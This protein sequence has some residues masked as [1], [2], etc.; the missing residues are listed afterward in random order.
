MSRATASQ[1]F[2]N[3][4]A[5][6]WLFLLQSVVLRA[7][8]TPAS[9]IAPL[10]KHYFNSIISIDGYNKPSVKLDT[11]SS[12]DK[13]LKNYGVKQLSV[14]FCLPLVTKDKRGTG[15]DSNVMA[16]THLLLTGNFISLQPVFSG[17]DNHRLVKRGIGLRYIYNT[18]KK[19]VWFFDVAPFVTRDVSYTSRAY[20]RLASTAVYSHN[21]SD[22]FNFRVGLTKSFMWGN[23]LY[24][25]FLGLRFGALNKTHL[26]IQFPRN[27]SFNVPVNRHVILGLYTRPQGG[28]YNF[29][30][31]DTL[32][33][34]ANVKTFHF[35][36]YELNTGLR[37][38]VRVG[39]HFG[40]FACSGISSRNNITFYSDA[41]NKSNGLPYRKY[42]YSAS[43]ARTGYLQLGLVVKLGKTR[44]ISNN[45]NL[46]DAIDLNSST[47]TNDGN[48]Q[49]QVDGKEKPLKN[50]N[51]ESIQ[52]L[53]DYNDF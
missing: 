11:S 26:S 32:Y 40:F 16:N 39:S 4:Q 28:M 3:L 13:R 46:Y 48:R 44:T 45:R 24:L 30:N 29:A 22:K 2:Y 19:G 41:V 18:G 1:T 35:T 37:V 53:I 49:I 52:D 20:R 17:I 42:F 50:P 33:F 14:A 25:P 34:N 9:T 15:A 12:L 51:L 43:P 5:W 10:P 7:Q 21:V 27:I 6:L 36:R 47:G 38:D 31:N 23:R 8:T